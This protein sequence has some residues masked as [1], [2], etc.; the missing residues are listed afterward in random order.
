MANN[1]IL[2]STVYPLNGLSEEEAE[3]AI[4]EA[5][6]VIATQL[7]YDDDDEYD[8]GLYTIEGDEVWF[9]HDESA[10]AE[11]VAEAISRLQVATKA[12]KPFIFSYCY[13]CSKARPDEFGGG[14]VGIMPDGEI[15][16]VDALGEVRCQV[17]EKM[18]NKVDP[19]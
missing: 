10:D 17:E 7:G 16:W 15:V 11:G 9:R 6:K 14:A 18:K 8:I 13:E 3:K 1:Y 4:R 12:T 2:L 19:K 5:Q